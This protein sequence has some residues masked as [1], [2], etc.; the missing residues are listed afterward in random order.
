MVEDNYFETKRKAL[1]ASIYG[2]RFRE[3]CRIYKEVAVKADEA[4][5]LSEVDQK[6]INQLQLAYKRLSTNVEEALAKEITKADRQIKKKMIRIVKAQTTCPD[7]VS[8]DAWF[9]NLGLSKEM[10]G[11]ML[12]TVALLQLTIGCSNF[13]RRCN[14]WA[15]PGVR[16]HFSFQAVKMILKELFESGNRE[17]ALYSASDPL[18]WRSQKKTIVD[19][20]GF[21][22]S[23][24]YDSKYGLLTK[25][26]GGSEKIAE[27]LLLMEADLAVSITKKNRAKVRRI[28]QDTGKR[29]E[30]HHDTEQ[31]EIPAGLDEDFS[32]IKP[33]ITDNY[34]TEITPEG[35]YL[36]IPTFTSA[37]HPTGQCRLRVNNHTGFFI[38]KRVGRDA[39]PV[40]YFKPLKVLNPQTEEFT[41]DDLLD[42]QIENILLDDGRPE[43]VPPGMMSLQEYFKIYEPEATECRRRL[44]DAV[45]NGLVKKLLLDGTI[46]DDSRKSR[47]EE[48][49]RRVHDYTE[50]CKTSKVTGFKKNAFSFFLKAVAGYAKTHPV[51]REIVL[52]LRKH[53]KKKYEKRFQDIGSGRKNDLESIIAKSTS[54]TFDLFEALMFKLLDNPHNKTI[55]KFIKS[56]PARYDVETDRFV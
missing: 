34:G 29:F 3:T 33:S 51:E 30:T 10:F 31:L 17:F 36:I 9:K 5:R 42:A 2:R 46:S 45:V 55:A 56:N 13:C 40:E 12:K 24:G 43:L 20:A 23:K 6:A 27:N 25:I 54:G 16:K 7:D 28:E 32:S 21:M 37:L 14:E 50:F 38:K 18:D 19:L 11:A 47:H 35:A 53:D 26:P 49:K 41:L 15:L 44:R 4:T 52:H 22:A 48:F 8:Y 39:L 1:I